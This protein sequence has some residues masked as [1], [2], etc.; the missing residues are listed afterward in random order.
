M[1]MHMIAAIIR[2]RSAKLVGGHRAI[3]VVKLRSGRL[4]VGI[5]IIPN[6]F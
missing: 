1:G 6:P 4:N 5:D 2:P 3:K